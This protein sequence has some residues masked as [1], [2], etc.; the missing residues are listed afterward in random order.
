MSEP[1]VEKMV[2]AWPLLHLN[3][4]TGVQ[5]CG[6]YESDKRKVQGQRSPHQELKVL[7]ITLTQAQCLR[8]GCR[9]PAHP[10]CR[11]VPIGI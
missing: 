7:G 2:W 10:I 6:C 1:C 4:I 11:A 8:R 9:V 5:S 3:L